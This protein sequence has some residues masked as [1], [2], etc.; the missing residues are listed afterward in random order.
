MHAELALWTGRPSVPCIYVD[1]VL[2]GG[3][4]ADATHPGLERALEARVK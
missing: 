2:A 4:D 3:F 1:G